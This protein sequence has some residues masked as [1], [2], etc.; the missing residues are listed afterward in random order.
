MDSN[1]QHYGIEKLEK[2]LPNLVDLSSEEM[3]NKL[4]KSIAIYEG[5]SKQADDITL[6]ALKYLPKAKNQE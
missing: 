3:V 2:N 5:E 4:I 6:V 1:N